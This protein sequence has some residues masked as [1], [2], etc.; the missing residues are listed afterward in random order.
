MS[1]VIYSFGDVFN[2]REKDY[3]LLTQTE[4]TIFAAEILCEEESANRKRFLMNTIKSSQKSYNLNNILLCIVE[5]PNTKEYKN[6][7][8][9]YSYP[10]KGD[11]SNFFLNHICK[12]ADTDSKNLLKEILGEEN[13]VSG[14]LK[15]KLKN[16]KI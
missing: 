15:A 16:I 11:F 1:P 3:I 7:V 4:D 9:D 14:I 6:R 2:Y 10:E 5:L 8:A 13:F 12:I